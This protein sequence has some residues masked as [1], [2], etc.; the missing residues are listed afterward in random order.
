MRG[1]GG[2]EIP[3]FA[4]SGAD[5]REYSGVLIGRKHVHSMAPTSNTFEPTT[6]QLHI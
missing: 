3:R 2:V 4:I 5:G 1:G 6:D